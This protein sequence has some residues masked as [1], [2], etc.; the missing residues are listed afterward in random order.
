MMSLVRVSSNNL[1][2]SFSFSSI[3]QFIEGRKTRF[4]QSDLQLH[5]SY[6]RLE[7]G[8]LIGS[9]PMTE[10]KTDQEQ[11]VAPTWNTIQWIKLN[12]FQFLKIRLLH[13]RNCAKH[14][15]KMQTVNARLYIKLIRKS[16]RRNNNNNGGNLAAV[17]DRVWLDSM[18]LCC[19][20]I[21]LIAG[22]TLFLPSEFKCYFSSRPD[23]T[24]RIHTIHLSNCGPIFNPASITCLYLTHY[25][26]TI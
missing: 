1:T 8:F 19:H 23:K 12:S 5:F 7:T 25:F 3:V 20:W 21:I 10:P 9:E 2:M 6:G 4:K 17:T 11:W 16:Q 26:S 22:L 15:L 13:F 14:W 24:Q 18:L